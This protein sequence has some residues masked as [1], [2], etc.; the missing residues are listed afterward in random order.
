MEMD[1]TN[2]YIRETKCPI[3]SDRRTDGH[4]TWRRLC[5][6]FVYMFLSEWSLGL[7]LLYCIRFWLVW[8][9]MQTIIQC[10]HLTAGLIEGINPPF[11]T[12]DSGPVRSVFR[13]QRHIG[14]RYATHDPWIGFRLV[15][16]ERA[17]CL[18]TITF[19]LLF[20]L[21]LPLILI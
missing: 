7:V 10:G 21:M 3:L 11:R 20:P 17:F 1:E 14:T 8:G 5:L 6:I 2:C 13:M 18:S 4:S 16:L 9:H 19:S 12:Q 15:F